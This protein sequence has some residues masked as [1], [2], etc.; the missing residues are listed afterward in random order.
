MCENKQCRF[1]CWPCM[2]PAVAVVIANDAGEVLV[3]E[4]ANEPGKGQLDWPGGFVDYQELPEDTAVREVK[5]ELGVAIKLGDFIGFGT[6]EYRYQDN[7]QI[8][9]GIGFK[10]RIVGDD[11]LRMAGGEVAAARWTDPTKLVPEDFA[12]ASSASFL[13]LIIQQ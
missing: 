13:R 4:R 6:D 10:A 11:T 7:V 1:E 9:L 8:N 3:I 12:F 2:Y 5:E